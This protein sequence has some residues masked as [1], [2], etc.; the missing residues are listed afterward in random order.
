MQDFTD[1]L[2]TGAATPGASKS[3]RAASCRMSLSS[4]RSA[5]ALR[6]R[7]FSV[8]SSFMRL[9]CS[10]FSLPYFWRHR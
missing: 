5:I 2:D 7:V 1:L 6:R 4:V 9:T 3:P 8:S 10:I